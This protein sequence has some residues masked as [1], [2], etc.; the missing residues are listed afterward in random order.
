MLSS[1]HVPSAWFEDDAF[2]EGMAPIM[3]NARRMARAPHEIEN[4]SRLIGL[5]P[6]ARV[7]DLCCGPGRHAVELAHRGAAV[8]AVDRTRAYLAAARELAAARGVA[9]E[10]VEDDMRRFRRP[11]AFDAVV[12]LYNS[13]GYS[14]DPADDRLVAQNMVA[15]LAPGGTAVIELVGKESLAAHWK[16][17]DWSEGDGFLVI[18]DRRIEPGWGAVECRLAVVRGAVRTDLVFRQR[19]YAAT[20]LRALLLAAGFARVE[21]HGSLAGGPYDHTAER[22]VAVATR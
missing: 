5:S 4:L 6:G 8:T 15:S 14:D 11:A 9:I 13:F 22:L 18:E 10:L 17:R 7:L 2:W 1:R 19:L 3:F 20:E 12:N 21:L 16:S